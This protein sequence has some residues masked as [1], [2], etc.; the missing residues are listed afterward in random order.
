[1]SRVI[2]FHDAAA[3]VAYANLT[4]TQ[5]EQIW[6][7]N[8]ASTSKFQLEPKWRQKTTYRDQSTGEQRTVLIS[9]YKVS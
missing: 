9:K 3:Y 8:C 6:E 1:M 5:P 4:L 2:C 7:K